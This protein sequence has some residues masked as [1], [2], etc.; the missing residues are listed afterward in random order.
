MSGKP[1]IR[2]ARVYDDPA[3]S[4]GARLLVDRVWPR[5]IR[6]E[7]LKHDDWIRDVAPSDALRRWFGHD[8]G[9]W[10]AFCKYYRAELDDNKQAV[11]RCLAWC[12]KG[13]VTLLYSARDRDRNQAVVLRQYLCQQLEAKSGA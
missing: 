4:A 1:D 8:P 9:K 6:K 12:R 5:G 10:D 3:G 2:I 13:P 11:A 7:D